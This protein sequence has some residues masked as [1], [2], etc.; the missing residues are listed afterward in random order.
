MLADMSV[1]RLREA[2]RDK[3]RIGALT[4]NGITSVYAVLI[5]EHRLEQFDGIGET[6]AKRIR[7]A[8][9]T[10]RQHKDRRNLPIVSPAA[11]IRLIA[12]QP[13]LADYGY[14]TIKNQVLIVNAMSNTIV[15]MF[16]EMQPVT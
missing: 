6:S 16:S 8:A 10:L 7:A 2:S 15:D 11:T 1:E 3:I 5:N 14:L 4:E 9:R 12:K 13:Q